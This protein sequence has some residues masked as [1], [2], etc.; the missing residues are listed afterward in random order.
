MAEKAD[1][2]IC[3]QKS[4]QSADVDVE[5]FEQAYE[6]AYG[7]KPLSLR[8]DFCGTFS[9]CC[10]WVK[11]HRKRTAIGIDLCPD[12]LQWG[13]DHNLAKLKPAQQMRVAAY[14]KDVRSL[15]K[16]KSDVLTAQN[17]SFWIF[18]TR[19]E[20]INYFKTV[21]ENLN[22]QGVFIMDMMGGEETY[23]EDYTEKRT[24][25]KGK[26][27]F[28]Y[29]W[30]QARF[31]P[32]NSH[33]TFYIHFKFAD[34]SRLKR[35]FEYHWRFWTIPEVREMLAE[36]GFSR[37]HVY[38]EIED[39]DGVDTGEWEISEEAPSHPSWLCYVVGIK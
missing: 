26:N 24:I 4:V 22:D 39:E 36:A 13:R 2:F 15:S 21:R 23:I 8:E 32:I 5:F 20:V 19:E 16:I 29:H 10:E 6:E 30:E 12:T 34:G 38:W 31:N 27:G 28:S 3:Y 37:S 7:G 11:S 18:K 25:T 14:E 1:K 9:V 33:C 17:F 35:A